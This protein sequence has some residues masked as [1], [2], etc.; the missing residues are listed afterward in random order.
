MKIFCFHAVYT[1]KITKTG[2][3]FD[4]DKFDMPVGSN[5]T[6]LGN[7]YFGCSTWAYF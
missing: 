5:E 6:Y 4:K 1:T 2:L 3:V 7:V